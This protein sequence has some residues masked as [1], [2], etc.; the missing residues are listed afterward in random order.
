MSHKIVFYTDARVPGG[1]ERV[2]LTLLQGLDRSTWEPALVYHPRPSILPI[3]DEVRRLGVRLLPVEWGRGR[4]SRLTALVPAL[5]GCLRAERPALMHANMTWPL[6]CRYAFVAGALARVPVVATEHLLVNVPS[7][8]AWV[9]RCVM[10]G[11]DRFIAVSQFVARGLRDRFH[12]PSARIRV[13]PNGIPRAF[14]EPARRANLPA[15]VPGR[16]DR[17]VVLTVARLDSAK[18]HAYLLR[19][20]ALLPDVDF[21]LAGDGP[22]RGPL[23]A[24]ARALGLEHRVAF[25][26]QRDDVLALLASATLL[27]LPSVNEGLPL[28][29]LEAMAAGRP[30]VASDVGGVSEAIIDGQTGILVPAADPARLAGAIRGLLE[31]RPRAE[32]LAAAARTRA[33]REFT[34]ETMVARTTAVYEELLHSRART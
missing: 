5:L 1:A 27:A 33:H 18:G 3:V 22:L 29:V 15:F 20:A 6:G 7:R 8:A 14:F 4:V 13:V 10:A 11:V 16:P 30:V 26:G 2:L 12:V 31:D 34:A 19:A 9:Q 32:R 25:L 28:V 24:Q 17:P 23:Q 21:R